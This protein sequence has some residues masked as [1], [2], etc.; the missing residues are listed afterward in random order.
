MSISAWIIL[1]LVV[2]VVLLG[3]ASYNRLVALRQQC[4]QAFAD[5]DV[6]LR[7]RHDLV[8]NLVEA[9]KGY[10]G[11]ER[12]TLDAVVQARNAAV[13]ARGSAAKAEAES[14]LG[15]ALRQ[16]FA[17]AEAY[18]NLKANSNF[19]QLQAE[20][21]TIENRLAAARRAFNAM[22]QGYNSMIQQLPTMLVARALGFAPHEFFGVGN[23]RRVVD[24]APQVRF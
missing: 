23:E 14:T 9:V 22:V 6:Q 3:F 1:T 17:L 13:A 8:T 4:N 16:L 12:G 10:A 24:E 21:T 7:Q 15:G 20:L 2:V 18:P 5:I 11:H 19:Q